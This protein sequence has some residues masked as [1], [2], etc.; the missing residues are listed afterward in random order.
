MPNT[1]RRQTGVQN[2][3]SVASLTT[4]AAAAVCALTVIGLS[5]PALAD[6][7]SRAVAACIRSVAH[8]VDV[9]TAS[10]LSL[11]RIGGGGRRYKVWLAAPRGEEDSARRFY[12]RIKR[13]GEVEEVTALNADG[14][15]NQMLAAR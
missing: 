15:P 4:F 12:C 7:Q 5:R 9:A 10:G 13:S 2:V 8:Q 1:S 3:V 6:D 11:D 14:S